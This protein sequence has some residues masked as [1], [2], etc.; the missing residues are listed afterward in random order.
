MSNKT[1]RFDKLLKLF[2]KS[3]KK[4]A[5]KCPHESTRIGDLV[6]DTLEVSTELLLQG[7]FGLSLVDIRIFELL[8]LMIHVL[9]LS[10][11]GLYKNAYDNLR[12]VLESAIQSVYIESKHSK[13]SLRTRI[14]ILREIENNREYRA[15]NLIGKLNIDHKETLQKEY[16]KLSQIIHPSH[17]SILQVLGFVG[18]PSLGSPLEFVTTVDCE[19]MSSVYDSMIMV[20]DMVLFLYASCAPKELKESLRCNQNLATYCKKYNLVLMLKI[21]K[22]KEKVK[23]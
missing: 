21:M 14:E 20:L 1:A 8:R 3:F 17:K 12:Y 22:P 4:A 23:K 16:G 11:S 7:K 9:Y 2:Q 18:K 15:K 10:L 19:E 5:Q 6:D 13:C